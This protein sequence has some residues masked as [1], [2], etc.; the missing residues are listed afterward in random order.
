MTL[1]EP[2]QGSEFKAAKGT[3]FKVHLNGK[4]TIF[5]DHGSKEMHEGL[6]HCPDM[7]ERSSDL[8]QLQIGKACVD[9]DKSRPA[10]LIEVDVGGPH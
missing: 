3:H 9:A 10:P 6:G 5:A 4:A 1:S 7:R 2:A 8:Q